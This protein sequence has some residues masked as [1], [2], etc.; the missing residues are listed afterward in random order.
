MISLFDITSVRLG[1]VAYLEDAYPIML[2]F[3]GMSC[4]AVAKALALFANRDFGKDQ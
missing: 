3:V 4:L 1:P 2:A